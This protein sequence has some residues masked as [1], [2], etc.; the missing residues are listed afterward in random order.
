MAD[1]IFGDDSLFSEFER[2]RNTQNI[3]IHY[4]QDDSGT[5]NRS[6][7]VFEAA[8]SGSEA[9]DDE[10]RSEIETGTETKNDPA[11]AENNGHQKS[12]EPDNSAGDQQMTEEPEP[13]EQE[14]NKGPQTTSY[15]EQFQKNKYRQIARLVD[16]ARCVTDEQ[17]PG[18]QVVFHNNK[19]AKKYRS[20]I[21]QFIVSLTEH[22]DKKDFTKVAAEFTGRISVPSCMDINDTLPPEKRNNR[23]L[24]LHEITGCAQF[25]HGFMVDSRGCPH[26]ADEPT[27][28]S[29]GEPPKYFQV[30][31]EIFPPDETIAPP[32]KPGRQKNSC[33]NCGGEHRLNECTL[34]KDQNRIRIKRR[35]Q[36][37]RSANS[38]PSNP[39]RY[40]ED[41]ELDPAKV[42][43]EAGIIRS[44]NRK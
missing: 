19:F 17:S 1:D 40:H 26:D 44:V 32:S 2:D 28:I 16:S 24:Q 20:R 7:I 27:E 3:F 42:K 5:E 10:D 39:N 30:F 33:F 9:S 23:M 11:A 21:E 4:D 34:P 14:A 29:R 38:K 43:F 18:V 36:Q 35:E 6:R 15:Q 22:S 12:P 13:R 8:E 25:H 37:D 41:P 31:D